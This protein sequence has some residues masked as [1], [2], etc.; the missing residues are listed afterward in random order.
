MK[1]IKM[2]GANI[3]WRQSTLITEENPSYKSIGDYMYH[4]II[5]HK[6]RFCND[7][8]PYQYNMRGSGLL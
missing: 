2:I 5:K 6:E 7:D 4:K 8:I 1:L 3:D